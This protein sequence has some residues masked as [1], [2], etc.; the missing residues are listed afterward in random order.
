MIHY[1]SPTY[2]PRCE[3]ITR[4][5]KEARSRCDTWCQALENVD[6]SSLSL[7]LVV[8]ILEICLAI[9]PPRFLQ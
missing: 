7:N 2:Q 8:A 4:R 5:S 9:W 3:M 6:I 1:L